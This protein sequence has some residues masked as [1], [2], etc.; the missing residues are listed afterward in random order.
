[1]RRWILAEVGCYTRS[2]DDCLPALYLLIID[3]ANDPTAG[4]LQNRQAPQNRA[5]LL[6]QAIP[7]L[8]QP[9]AVDPRDLPHQGH[10]QQGARQQGVR[11][12]RLLQ[13]PHPKQRPPLP[14]EE[15]R[16]QGRVAAQHSCRGRRGG[17]EDQPG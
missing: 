4:L 16:L 7:D 17:G 11:R 1:M 14:A 6:L 5:N 9:R 13:T 10:Q 3:T 8:L 15:E 2:L 12:H